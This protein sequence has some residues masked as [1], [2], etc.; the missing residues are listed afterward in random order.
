MAERTID[1]GASWDF[2]RPA[3]KPRILE[4]LQRNADD[5]F[6]VAEPVERWNAPTACT[7]WEVRDMVGHLVDAG[8]SF[9]S[10]FAHARNGTTP[11]EPIGSAGMADAS[12]QAAQA[13]RD[14]PRE[15][16]LERLHLTHDELM[17]QFAALSDADW[18]DLLVHDKYLGPLPAMI[19][20]VGSLGGYAVHTWDI[21]EG[22]GERHSLRADT[23][24][25]LVPFVFLLWSVTAVPRANSEPYAVG[26]RTSGRNARAVRADV[27]P[28]G[29][30]FTNASVDDCRTI[31]EFDPAS[32]VLTAY[33]RVNAGTIHGEPEAA[34]DFLSRFSSL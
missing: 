27:T 15:A 5:F 23:A 8:E 32:L 7:G 20:A 2:G 19:V 34:R 18:T 4:A 22:I 9:I 10:G 29:V 21:Y 1:D 6:A 13:F 30:Q 25:L 33:G 17:Q 3:S 28:D 24:D 26:I 11:P 14:E 16:L 31:V 12:D